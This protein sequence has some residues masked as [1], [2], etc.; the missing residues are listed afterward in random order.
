MVTITPDAASAARAAASRITDSIAAALAER[1]V[2]H[3]ALAGGTTPRR[4]YEILASEISDWSGVSFWFGDERMLPAG[5]P[6]RNATML[7]ETFRRLGSDHA[8]AIE[9]VPTATTPEDA[10]RRYEARLRE[11]VTTGADGVPVF[12]LA[13]LGLG[14]DGHT[15]SL[16]PGH[17]EVDERERL[18]VSVRNAPKPPPERVSM[19]IPLLSAARSI[20]ILATGDGK[21]E[22]VGTLSGPSR[23]SIPPGRL[24]HDR[25]ELICDHEAAAQI[26]RS[27]S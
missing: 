20:V 11:R 24:P 5:D 26:G 19:T 4:A 2:A 17:P 23:E 22:A 10:A 8:P 13:I 6:E 3:L 12:D 18:I 21:A 14:E 27:Q 25:V 9:E 7:I 16:F 15:A 1:R